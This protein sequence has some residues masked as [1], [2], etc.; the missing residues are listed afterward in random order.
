VLFVAAGLAAIAG[1]SLSPK[2][3]CQQPFALLRCPGVLPAHSNRVLAA[4]Y[5]GEEALR[6][7]LQ[8]A[9]IL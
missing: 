4:Q 1:A 7:H 5:Y 3:G 9:A 8:I 6:A 2:Q